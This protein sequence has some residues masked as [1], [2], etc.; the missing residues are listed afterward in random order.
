VAQIAAKAPPPPPPPAKFVSAAQYVQLVSATFA[1]YG[2]Q[3]L[4]VPAMMVTMHF[5]ATC[6]NMTRFWIRGSSIGFLGLVYALQAVPTAAA[7]SIGLAT[8]FACGVA[9]PWNTKFNLLKDNLSAKYP[10]HYVPE[11]IMAVLTLIGAYVI[12]L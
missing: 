10:M 3:M 6:D 9:Y 12:Y 1:F 2:L 11:V 7:A 8:S 5:N 4:L